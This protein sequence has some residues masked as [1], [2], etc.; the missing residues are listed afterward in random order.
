MEMYTSAAANIKDNIDKGTAAK[1]SY[2]QLQQ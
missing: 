2:L 1:Q